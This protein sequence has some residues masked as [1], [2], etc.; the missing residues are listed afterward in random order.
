MSSFNL[1]FTWTC[2]FFLW[3]WPPGIVFQQLLSDMIE[4]IVFN[5]IDDQHRTNKTMLGKRNPSLK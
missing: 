5:S 1:Y 4:M 3:L 2:I